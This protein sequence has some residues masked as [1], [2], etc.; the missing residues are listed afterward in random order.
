MHT[1]ILYFCSFFAVLFVTFT[2]SSDHS[3]VAYW[4]NIN[5]SVP[6]KRVLKEVLK[7]QSVMELKSKSLELCV[8]AV[9][10][11]ATWVVFVLETCYLIRNWNTVYFLNID[12]S[13][14]LPPV[15]FHSIRY[16]PLF[17][18]IYWKQKP[19]VWLYCFNF[20]PVWHIWKPLLTWI[21]LEIDKRNSSG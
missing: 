19:H 7:Q 9:H 3:G 20:H 1:G 16:Y 6:K 15:P 2:S 12:I 5:N 13:E 21:S 11:S 10:R 4:R 17:L 8:N 18:F 14:V